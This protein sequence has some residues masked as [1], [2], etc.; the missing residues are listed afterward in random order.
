MPFMD[1]PPGG[2]VST[3]VAGTYGPIIRKLRGIT[4]KT[5]NKETEVAAQQGQA[6]DGLQPALAQVGERGRH[7]G[8]T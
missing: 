2:G 6:H 1:A 4:N 7:D 5:I 3:T 8:H